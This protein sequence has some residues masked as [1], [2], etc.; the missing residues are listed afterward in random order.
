MVGKTIPSSSEAEEGVI[1][2]LLIEGSTLELVIENLESSDFSNEK[3]RYIYEAC[4]SLYQRGEIVN[5]I[6]IGNELTNRDKFETIGGTAYLSYLVSAC[7]TPLDIEHYAD[8]VQHFAKARRL[9][10]VGEKI[11][12]IGYSAPENMEAVLD[13]AKALIDGVRHKKSRYPEV[14]N[15]RILK[16][17]PP[18]YLVNVNDTELSLSMAELAQ[19]GRFKTKVMAELDFIP[20]LPKNWTAFVNRLLEY[21]TKV[22]TPVDTSADVE[23]RLLVRQYLEQRGV[24]EEYSDIKSGS[25]IIVKYQG[26]EYWGFQRNPLLRWLKRNQVKITSDGLWAMMYTWGGVRHQWR[27]GKNESIPIRLWALPP[28]F[29]RT[30]EYAVEEEEKQEVLIP[31]EEISNEELPDI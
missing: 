5:Q 27:I 15:L 29:A 9:I 14:K 28:D 17:H 11:T 13:E 22:E 2:S 12:N 8:T 7:P 4:L 19:P 23:T 6:A 20:V 18:H 24:G 30:A 25:Y 1:G 3:C 21:A 26:K 31:R 16:S 10:E